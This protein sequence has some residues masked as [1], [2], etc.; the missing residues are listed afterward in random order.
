MQY[1]FLHVCH[2]N[3]AIFYLTSAILFFVLQFTKMTIFLTKHESCHSLP[4]KKR[5]V[6]CVPLTSKAFNFCIPLVI[7][8]PNRV[9]KET[10]RRTS[11]YNLDH[12]ITYASNR[13]ISPPPFTFPSTAAL[14]SSPLIMHALSLAP[15]PNSIP[16]RKEELQK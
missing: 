14:L 1:V 10:L 4:D 13:S 15:K 16:F 9:N 12:K 6:I 2:V 8:F 7:P 11:F 3:H 5:H